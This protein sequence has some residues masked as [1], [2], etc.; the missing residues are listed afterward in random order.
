M[1]IAVM[2]RELILASVA[3]RSSR[4]MRTTITWPLR[5][6]TAFQLLSVRI[7]YRV[8]AFL[9]RDPVRSGCYSK[10]Q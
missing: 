3:D 6:A 2:V 4:I 10:Q 7:R 8:A 9:E 5:S 1:T